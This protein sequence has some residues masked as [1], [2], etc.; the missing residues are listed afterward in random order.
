MQI[1]RNVLGDLGSHICAGKWCLPSLVCLGNLAATSLNH[2]KALEALDASET[3]VCV[4][5]LHFLSSVRC[6][7]TE[8]ASPTR[9][10][11][12]RSGRNSTLE[13]IGW[14]R[15]S[16]RPNAL[17]VNSGTSDAGPGAR[18]WHRIRGCENANFGCR[19]AKTRNTAKSFWPTHEKPSDCLSFG[20]APIRR[21]RIKSCLAQSGKLCP[22]VSLVEGHGLVRN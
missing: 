18:E 9:F 21:Q 15:Q 1:V 13:P 16:S 10:G 14:I 8:S 7:S 6:C 3:P 11:Q 4:D 17:W 20:L 22:N 5:G 12:R 19:K 2:R